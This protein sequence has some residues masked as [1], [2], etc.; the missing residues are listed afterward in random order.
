LRTERGL[1]GVPSAANVSTSLLPA[2]V[3]FDHELEI[4]GPDSEYTEAGP[5]AFFRNYRLLAGNDCCSDLPRRWGFS[6]S[7]GAPT[8]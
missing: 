6:Y 8:H 4:S 3:N 2:L 7:A 5:L 1:N